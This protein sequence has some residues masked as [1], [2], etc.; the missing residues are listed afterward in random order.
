LVAAAGS[1]AVEERMPKDIDVVVIIADNEQN[2]EQIFEIYKKFYR[3]LKDMYTQHRQKL[4]L[5][6][7]GVLVH[8]YMPTYFSL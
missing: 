8:I 3:L 4:R 2:A 6:F 7:I 5:L 1:W